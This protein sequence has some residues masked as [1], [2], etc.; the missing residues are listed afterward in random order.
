MGY[1]LKKKMGVAHMVAHGVARPGPP[2]RLYLAFDAPSSNISRYISL[3][4]DLKD[5][6][7]PTLPG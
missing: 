7:A 5:L 1:H 3:N 6:I 2:Q 4:R